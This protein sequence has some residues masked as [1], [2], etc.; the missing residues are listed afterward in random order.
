MLYLPL[1]FH[2]DPFIRVEVTDHNSTQCKAW[3]A[4]NSGHFKL[5]NF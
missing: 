2:Q 4:V 1:R 5:P 3:V